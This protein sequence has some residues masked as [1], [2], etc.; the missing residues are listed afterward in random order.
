MLRRGLTENEACLDAS[1]KPPWGKQLIKIALIGLGKMGISH[2]AIVNSHPD[3]ELVAV[4]DTTEYL[5]DVLAKYTAIKTYSD[6][7]KLLAAET[8]DAVLIATPSRYHAEMVRAAL[9]ANLHVFCE[10]PFC[11][12]VAEGLALAALAQQKNRVNQVGYHYRFVEVF[13]EVKKLLE[14]GIIGKLHHIRTEAYGPVVLRPKGGTWRIRKSEGGGCLYDYASH[15]I[16]LANYLVGPPQAVGGTTL[17]SVFSADVEDEVYTNFFYADG[18]TGQVAANWSDDSLRKMSAKVNIWGTNGRIAADRQEIQIYIRDNNNLPKGFKKG[19][20]VRYGTELADQVW[21]YLRGEEY[22]AQI[23]H[24]VQGIKAG[25]VDTRSTFL[26]AANT[27]LVMSTMVR[28][29]GAGRTPVSA[30]ETAALPV[31]ENRG[32]WGSIFGSG[33]REASARNGNRV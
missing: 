17:N 18:M 15:A 9:D 13:H 12:D 30:D 20:T 4:C 31:I 8:L 29:V 10:K 3:L 28:D 27:D 1:G 32:F 2:Q 24:F 5:L 16:D 7:R 19:W 33:S 26:S 11:L 23:D 25:R 14:M 22:S 6:Y 21:Y